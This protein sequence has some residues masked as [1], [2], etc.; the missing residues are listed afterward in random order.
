M[1]ELHVRL[2]RAIQVLTTKCEEDRYYDY[3]WN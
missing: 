2:G 1:L 3:K